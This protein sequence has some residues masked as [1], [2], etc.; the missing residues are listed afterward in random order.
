MSEIKNLQALEILDSRGNPTVQVTATLASGAKASLAFP[1][2]P[3]R[4]F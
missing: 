1:P 4:A 3:R 2:A